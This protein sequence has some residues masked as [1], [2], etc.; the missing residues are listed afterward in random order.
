VIQKIS[1]T[2]NEV[3]LIHIKRANA[4]SVSISQAKARKVP[5]IP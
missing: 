4:L 5:F 3:S 1:V 2:A